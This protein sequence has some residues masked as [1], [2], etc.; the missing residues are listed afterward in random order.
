MI[1]IAE[2][3]MKDDEEASGSVNRD[4]RAYI[5]GIKNIKSI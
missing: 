3:Q 2:I 4:M 1:T 5:K